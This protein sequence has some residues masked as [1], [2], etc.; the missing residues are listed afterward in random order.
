MSG[1]VP[2]PSIK[3]MIGLSGTL[4]LPLVRVI[5]AP[6]VGIL[7]FLNAIYLLPALS[8]EILCRVPPARRASALRNFAVSYNKDFPMPAKA[9]A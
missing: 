4:S 6:S 9:I 5:F 3:G 8:R 7:M 2:S 1:P